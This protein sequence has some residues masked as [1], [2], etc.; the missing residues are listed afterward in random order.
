MH[1]SQ[2]NERTL[3]STYQQKGLRRIRKL[4]WADVRFPPRSLSGVP[5]TSASNLISPGATT[6]WPVHSVKA[7][8][9]KLKTSAHRPSIPPLPSFPHTPSI[10]IF[11]TL[12]PLQPSTEDFAFVRCRYRVLNLRPLR[13][14][15]GA[16]TPSQWLVAS[17]KLQRNHSQ[18]R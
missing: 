16:F 6:L 2:R 3:T 18:R 11:L 15:A 9:S 13:C 4:W 14:L 12:S 1:H 10:S 17:L 5:D 8:H 7:T